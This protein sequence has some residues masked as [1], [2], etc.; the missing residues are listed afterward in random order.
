MNRD[1]FSHSA[2]IIELA[3]EFGMSP[4]D[5]IGY[6]I[7]TGEIKNISISIV[8]NNNEEMKS[9]L[10]INAIEKL[11]NQ[12]TEQI[13]ENI[14]TDTDDNSL[15]NAITDCKSLDKTFQPQ[16]SCETSY[17][18]DKYFFSKGMIRIKNEQKDNVNIGAYVYTTGD[19]L[20]IPNA[21]P[22]INMRGI[23]LD[24]NKKSITLINYVGKDFSA[25]EATAKAKDG[26][27]FMSVNECKLFLSRCDKLNDSL[28]NIRRKQIDDSML[29]LCQG[30]D[31]KLK[32]FDVKHQT[33]RTDLLPKETTE[34]RTFYL[35]LTKTLQIV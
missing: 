23:I 10:D 15:S 28:R 35:Y 3:N 33:L 21:I 20:P 22:K 29:L 31:K 5:L 26:W 1:E 9:N 27:H 16:T 7:K 4:L 14:S 8:F 6:W 32:I 25:I 13:S 18:N 17:R 24:Y 12:V 19:I 2:L 30:D 11:I 34:D